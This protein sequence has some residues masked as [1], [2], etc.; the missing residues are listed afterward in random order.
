MKMLRMCSIAALAAAL[1]ACATQQQASGTPHS[2]AQL[3][4]QEL[5]QMEEQGQRNDFD[6]VKIN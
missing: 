5:K 2:P 6:K 3:K 1:A 4:Q